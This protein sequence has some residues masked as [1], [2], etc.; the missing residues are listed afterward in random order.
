[1]ECR[2]AER[3][4]TIGLENSMAEA[5]RHAYYPLACNNGLQIYFG[6]FAICVYQ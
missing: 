6:S 2:E 5:A 4:A 1:M 3:Y